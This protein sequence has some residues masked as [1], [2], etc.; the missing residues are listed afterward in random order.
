VAQLVERQIE[1]PWQD[2][3]ARRTLSAAQRLLRVLSPALLEECERRE[4]EVRM[5]G[6]LLL[7]S[8]F[9]SLVL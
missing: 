2:L 5:I 7:A 1:C 3:P 4:A 9:R 6:S 8:V